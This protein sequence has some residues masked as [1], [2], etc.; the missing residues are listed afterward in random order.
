MTDERLLR[1]QGS[2]DVEHDKGLAGAPLT[3]KQAMTA[4]GNQVLDQPIL[5]RPRI[6]I[7]VGIELRQLGIGRRLIF[8]FIF[9]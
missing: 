4:G 2:K 8:E 5:Q 1:R 6:W 9:A 3:T 7:A